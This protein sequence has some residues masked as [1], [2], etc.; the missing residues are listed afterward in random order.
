MLIISITGNF[1]NIKFGSSISIILKI[2]QKIKKR[3]TDLERKLKE[4]GNL[5][6]ND[7]S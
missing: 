5:L 6:D 7:V 2:L 4:L 1:L 3:R